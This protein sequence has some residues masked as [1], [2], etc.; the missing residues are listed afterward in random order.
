MPAGAAQSGKRSAMIGDTLRTV[1]LA[2]LLGGLAACGQIRAPDSGVDP[3]NQPIT[4]TPRLLTQLR[5]RGVSPVG[6]GDG[7]DFSLVVSNRAGRLFEAHCATGRG[8]IVSRQSSC[9][10][11][12][13]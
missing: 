11:S 7:S 5:L 12:L 1:A 2:A 6:S 10:T 3:A 4:E 13:C 8:C 9:G